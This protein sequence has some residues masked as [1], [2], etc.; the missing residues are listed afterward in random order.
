MAIQYFLVGT[1]VLW[2]THPNFLISIGTCN[3][4]M[5]NSLTTR[6]LLRV[7]ALVWHKAHSGLA[8]QISVLIADHIVIILRRGLTSRR[9]PCLLGPRKPER[10]GKTGYG[11]TCPLTNTTTPRFDSQV[12]YTVPSNSLRAV[13]YTVASVTTPFSSNFAL[14]TIFPLGCPSVIPPIPSTS[15]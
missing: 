13:L 4:C 9:T 10:E 11:N 1:E 5:E 2:L 6:R 8:M 12:Q 15:V 3:A 14:T 7:L